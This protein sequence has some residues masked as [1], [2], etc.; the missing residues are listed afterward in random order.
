MV[1]CLTPHFS[2]P[3]AAPA[4]WLDSCSL[5]DDQTRAT[6]T[7]SA[8]RLLKILSVLLPLVI[9]FSARTEEF[10]C[11]LG[12]RKGIRPVKSWVLV[13]WW[14]WFEWSFAR[15]IVVATTSIAPCWLRGCKNRPAPFPGRM[16]YK[17]TKP[18]SVCPRVLLNMCDVTDVLLT[19]ASLTLL[20]FVLYVYSVSWLYLLGCQ[21][22]C[23]WLTG[24]TRL[25]NDLCGWGR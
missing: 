13:C 12:D 14:W 10:P 24:K 18:G 8:V 4:V 20:F 22:Q 21:Y 1:V 23:K 9:A 6:F 16:S 3:S 17:P 2:L 15:L 19:R 7:S 5:A 25:R 11:W